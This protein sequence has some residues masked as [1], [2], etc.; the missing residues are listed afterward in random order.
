MDN[1][2]GQVSC[3]KTFFKHISKLFEL[4]GV[5]NKVMR[6]PYHRLMQFSFSTLKNLILI[7]LGIRLILSHSIL[8]K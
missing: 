1:K 6:R 5:E 4:L 7:G 8:T 2:L 3:V